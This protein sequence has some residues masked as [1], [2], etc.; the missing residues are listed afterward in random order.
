MA[1]LIIICTHLVSVRR[2]FD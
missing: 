2:P 1:P